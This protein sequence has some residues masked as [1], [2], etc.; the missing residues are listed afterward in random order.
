VCRAQYGRFLYFLN[1]CFPSTLLGYC[2]CD[3]E[4]VPAAPIITGITFLFTFHVRW[5]SIRSYYYYYYYY[6]L[7]ERACTG[8]VYCVSY[9]CELTFCTVSSNRLDVCLTL[10]HQTQA[11]T[12]R[13]KRCGNLIYNLL[14]FCIYGS[15]HRWSILIIVQRNAT[16]SSLFI[17]MQIHS[18]VAKLAWPRW[19]E[20][21]AQ[22]IWPVPE[23]VVTVCVLL[24]MGVVDTWKM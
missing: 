19:R 7:P 9:F 12:D 15:V 18:N 5:I 23:T 22:K 8:L 21:A 2:L 6:Y 17:I 13:N 1:Y 4:M 16:Q 20:V 10:P 11:T 3:F 14:H 24:M